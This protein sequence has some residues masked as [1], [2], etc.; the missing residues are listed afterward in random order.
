MDS[1]QDRKMDESDQDSDRDVEEL[2][3]RRFAAVD[4][5]GGQ[6]KYGADGLSPFVREASREVLDQIR[7]IE[8]MRRM[9]LGTE[10]GLPGAEDQF[11]VVDEIPIDG[12]RS[13]YQGVEG[14]YSHQAASEYFGR[15][16][17]LVAVPTF[18]S[19]F[20]AV[21]NK[22]VDYAVLPIENTTGGAVGDVLDLQMKYP[23]Y[24][25]AELDLPI[26]H[27]LLGVPGSTPDQIDTVYSHPQG[28]L[29]CHN[30]LEAHPDWSQV[31]LS[32]TA[33]SAK[34]VAAEGNPHHAAI[35]S[36]F[37]GKLYGLQVLKHDITDRAGNTTRFI[38]LTSRKIR[39]W[40]A[41]KIRICFECRHT[42]GS[43]YRLL[44]NFTF[45]R[46]NMTKI[47]SRPLPGR[48]FEYRF[49]VEFEGRLS[50]TNVQNALRG[51]RAE[52]SLFRLLGNF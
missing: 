51:I 52:A 20:R 15:R 18:E 41:H 40:D 14:A 46:V 34:K 22:E 49:F 35:A 48:N 1:E 9:E 25:V 47:E 24:T 8:R 10:N 42:T 7:T 44:A 5:S 31:P 17:D 37:C 50:D 3:R 11:E 4:E 28:L 45:N 43:L 27:A 33:A 26:R 21:V 23:C 39:R 19:A 32:N 13:A 6:K 16:A 12:T 2:L 29:Q 36:A 30:F 38:V